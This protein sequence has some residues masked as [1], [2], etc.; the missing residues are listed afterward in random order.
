MARAL[1]RQAAGGDRRIDG[2]HGHHHGARRLERRLDRLFDK[3][4]VNDDGAIDKD[5]HWPR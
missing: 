3:V 5:E 2:G 1:L 4:D